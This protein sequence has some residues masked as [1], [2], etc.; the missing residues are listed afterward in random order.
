MTAVVRPIGVEHTKL[1][2]CWFAIFFSEMLLSV[3]KISGRHRETELTTIVLKVCLGFLIES[4]K[5]SD[6]CGLGGFGAL[7]RRVN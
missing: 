7:I 5:D 3:K 1:G 2:D 6:V 4:L